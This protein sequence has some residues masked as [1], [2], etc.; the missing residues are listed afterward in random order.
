MSKFFQALLSGIFFTYFLDFFFF[1][2]LKLNY[3]DFYEIDIYY[4]I[5]FADNQNIFIFGILSLIIGFFIIYINSTSI[6]VSVVSLL[7]L[8]SA[9]T[10]IPKVGYNVGEF[11]F[12]KKNKIFKNLRHTFIGD[13]YYNGRKKITFYDYDL[14]KII[15]L[16]KKELIK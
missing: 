13:I 7:F 2:G 3:I 8:I 11:I 1:L 6:K 4:N 9:S 14:K 12:M 10:I 5:F 16:D 15:L